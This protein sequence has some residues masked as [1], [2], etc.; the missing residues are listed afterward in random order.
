MLTLSIAMVL[1]GAAPGATYDYR[2]TGGSLNVSGN[3]YD[4]TSATKLD[5]GGTPTAALPSSADTALVRNGT[6]VTVNNSLSAW[7]L[8]IG[9]YEYL[10]GGTVLPVIPKPTTTAYIVDGAQV[11][12]G[13]DG[14]FKVGN[15]YGGT[16]YQTG[17]TVNG[18][19]GN[20]FF[21]VADHVGS[22][23][24]TPVEGLYS[25]SGGRLEMKYNSRIGCLGGHGV[26]TQT[27]G[28]AYF[29]RG[30]SED[31]AGL[32]VGERNGVDASGTIVGGGEYNLSGTAFMNAG[33]LYVGTA[34]SGATNP[35]YAGSG[36]F[37]Q[38]GGQVEVGIN[39]G[40][41][42]YGSLRVGYHEGGTGAYNLSGGTLSIFNDEGSSAY[43]GHEG[44]GLLKQT[45]GLLNVPHGIRMGSRIAGS[46][47]TGMHGELQLLGG[48]ANLDAIFM[49]SS[50]EGGTVTGTGKTMLSQS[51]VVTLAGGMHMQ[52]GGSALEV[53]LGSTNPFRFNTSGVSNSLAGDLIVTLIGGYVPTA[54]AEWKL[55]TNGLYSGD[56]EN[57]STDFDTEVRGSDLYLKYLGSAP[58]PHPGDANNDGYVNVGDLGILAGNWGQSPRT[59]AQG[60][61]TTPD[62]VVDVGDL[63]V[64]AGNWGWTAPP[65]LPA[66]EPASLMLLSLGGLV[67][68]R[69]KR[70]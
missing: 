4:V 38:S 29:G 45:G 30:G 43:I 2:G 18:L 20:T 70:K 24:V 1:A 31:A 10:T 11:T 61:F 6:T 42:T 37:N 59:W 68:L 25:M 36:V 69:R 5:G 41:F 39:L 52:S 67:L 53:L 13:S 12:L 8:Y 32:L 28:S 34:G 40:G 15:W 49:G 58:Q 50:T 23:G 51:A 35:G 56:F 64:L 66:P 22:D 54:S 48:T 19:L 46:E 17:G 27:G 7:K 57:I 3:W 33:R 9:G 55:V 26:F 47:V 21:Y 63:G 14:A 65:S 62:T 16:C 44:Q 60:N